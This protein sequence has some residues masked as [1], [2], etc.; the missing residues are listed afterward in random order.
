M[1]WIVFNSIFL[2]LVLFAQMAA[3]RKLQ[4][5]GSA[6]VKDD[7]NAVKRKRANSDGISE[8]VARNLSSPKGTGATRYC[9]FSSFGL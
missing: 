5:K 8:R 7:P 9:L 2:F 6:I 1:H 3:V 4:A